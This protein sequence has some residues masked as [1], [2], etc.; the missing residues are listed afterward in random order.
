MSRVA[1]RDQ[2]LRRRRGA[3]D[4]VD[5]DVPAGLAHRR[6]R[7][8]RLR[9][10]HAAAP[11]R[12]LPRP[13]RRHHPLR[14]PGGRRRRAGRVPPQQRRVGYVPQEG[15]LFP[16]LDVAANIGFG[17]PRAERRGRP[18]R[19][20]ARPGR[21]AARRT[22]AGTRTSSPA[23]SSS[24]SPWPGR[25]RPTRRVVLL[26]EPFSSLDAALRASTGR[27]VVRALRA[28]G[29]TAVLV[30]H[31]QDE[32]LSLA[33]QVAVMRARPARPGRPAARP[34]P[35]PR[36]RRG[37]ARSSAVRRSCPATVAGGVADLRA[38]QRAGRTAASPTARRRSWSAPEQV[39]VDGRRPPG[40][41][42]S[43]EVALLRPRRRGPARAAARR[44]DRGRPRARPGSPPSR[45]PT[46]GVG[47]V[48]PGASRYPAAR[49]PTDA[50]KPYLRSAG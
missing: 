23:A 47:V 4:G 21:A 7:P 6:A 26:D 15:A 43:S 45:A 25:W 32:A 16:H 36:R 30:T 46:V 3:V 31:D 1:R 11:R 10:D 19:R 50:G 29:A 42:A 28:A 2:A 13:R 34:L 41:A 35:H 27:A 18:R 14:R 33:D 44:P 9:Q 49:D 24:G 39:A 17:L 5:L 37:R 40:A 48:G 12:R 20:A 38:R 8:V 22:P